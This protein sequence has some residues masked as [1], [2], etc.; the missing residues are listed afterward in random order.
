MAFKNIVKIIEG[1]II[2]YHCSVRSGNGPLRP[3]IHD[4]ILIYY[5][6]ASASNNKIAVLKNVATN[7]VNIMAVISA[8][9]V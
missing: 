4:R 2:M 3:G 8:V 6:S 7:I 1:A 5:K 9:S